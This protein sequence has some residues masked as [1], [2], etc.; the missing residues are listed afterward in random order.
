MAITFGTVLRVEG[1]GDDRGFN[2]N[3]QTKLIKVA[4]DMESMA[5]A[6][7]GL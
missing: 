5:L 3:R 2:Y 6:V 7:W 4:Q 1:P